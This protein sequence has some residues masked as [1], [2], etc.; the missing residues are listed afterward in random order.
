E[1]YVQA[2]GRVLACGPP[3]ARVDGAA[4]DRGIKAAASKSWQ[5]V[6]VVDA[7]NA[8]TALTQADGLTINRAADDKGLLFH[9]RR[10]LDDGEF[11]FLVN[12]SIDH[13]S[14]GEVSCKARGIEIW[15]P[16]TGKIAPYNFQ[17]DASGVKTDFDLPPCGSLLLFF[18]QKPVQPAGKKN[19]T[20]TAVKASGPTDVE[21]IGENVLTLDF[22][23]VTAGGKTQKNVYAFAAGMFAF[24]QN[25][26]SGNP[27]N[28][29]VQLHDMLIKKKF[30]PG[31][32]FE[33]TYRFKLDGPAPKP[34]HIVIERPD[35]Y[36]ITCNGKPVTAVEGRWW[37][38]KSFGMVDI[39]STVVEG[40]NAVT[41]KASPMTMFHEIE[42]AYLL[43]D[44]SVDPSDK[45]F[46]VSQA[47]PLKLDTRH[48][49]NAQG[50]PFYGHDVCYTQEYDI[51]KPEGH[52]RVSLPNW[53]G[54]V[55]KVLVNG[56]KAGT[57]GYRPYQCDVTKFIRPGKNKV[58]VVVTGTL[59][60]TLGPHHCGELM[61]M[62][63]PG[64]FQ[65]S[66]KTGPP[67]GSKYQ[68]LSYGLFEPFVLEQV[69]P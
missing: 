43:G 26:M 10:R 24:Q 17:K 6:S 54:S 69:Q 47:R 20:I 42:P 40:D 25:G 15:D 39:T 46:T 53:Y 14:R 48:G 2:G 9:Q 31:S 38:D 16:D 61:G 44:F 13:P 58:Q 11:L 65:Q 18:C 7:I 33:A 4:S 49:W 29:Q 68:S 34:L 60:N 22:V 64:H 66:P 45:G 59:K 12:T 37:L 50:M 1:Q 5:Q 52:Y 51:A 41:I 23:D 67:P 63:G 32:G 56:T 27:W 19:P 62:A 30:P 55:A 3:P 57:I 8:A 28:R 36:T 35:L 21:R